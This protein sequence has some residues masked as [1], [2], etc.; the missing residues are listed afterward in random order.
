M[1][2]FSKKYP[3]IWAKLTQ[4]KK[5]HVRRF[6]KNQAPFTQNMALYMNGSLFSWKISNCM[7]LLSNFAA[8]HLYQNQTLIP[9]PPDELVTFSWKIGICMGLF[10]FRSGTSLSK[11]NFE[12]PTPVIHA[13]GN[14]PRLIQC[15]KW[16]LSET[17]NFSVRWVAPVLWTPLNPMIALL[18]A[19]SLISNRVRSQKCQNLNFLHL[20]VA[21]LRKIHFPKGI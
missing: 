16:S 18:K 15:V 7:G 21:F 9:P 12:Y 1:G 17:A 19:Y 3:Q 2:W 13:E 8:A 14:V 11:P 6:W 10:K 5:I 4:F 20:F